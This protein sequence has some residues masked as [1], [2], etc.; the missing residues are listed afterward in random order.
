MI[1]KEKI[2]RK[3]VGLV[4]YHCDLALV[5]TKSKSPS[6]VSNFQW[7]Q[8]L[9]ENAPNWLKIAIVRGRVQ[10]LSITGIFTL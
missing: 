8:P 2:R 6:S 7:S 3:K 5:A 10:S 9:R 1:G 4:M